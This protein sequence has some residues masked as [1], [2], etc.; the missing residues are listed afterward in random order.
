MCIKNQLSRQTGS[1]NQTGPKNA[2]HDMGYLYETYDQISDFCHQVAEKN[3]LEGRTDRGKTVYLPPP[4][5]SGGII[6]S[7]HLL[8]IFY[9]FLLVA[10]VVVHERPKKR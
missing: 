1:R 8:P 2:S 3:I 5:G 9:L 10:R 7:T 6:R 4:S